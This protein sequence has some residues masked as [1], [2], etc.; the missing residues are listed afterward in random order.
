MNKDIFSIKE[1]S[2]L[3]YQTFSDVNN[4]LILKENCR[5]GNNQKH[6]IDLKLNGGIAHEKD[7]YK[8]VI[9]FEAEQQ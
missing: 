8:T 3:N 2:E 9:K 5:S 4:K 7:V 1:N 6:N